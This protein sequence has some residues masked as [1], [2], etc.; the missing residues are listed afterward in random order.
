MSLLTTAK[1][2]K[3]LFEYIAPIQVSKTPA[4]GEASAPLPIH[5]VAIKATVSKNGV[6]YLPEEL[7]K[8]AET[9]KGKPII[10]DHEARMDNV[11][12]R[13][14]DSYYVPETQQV[15]FDGLVMDAKMQEMVLDGRAQEVSIGASVENLVEEEVNGETALTAY[16]MSGDELS[17]VVKPGVTGAGLS[18]SFENAMISICE[19]YQNSK[20]NQNKMT[21]NKQPIKEETQPPAPTAA[22][23]APASPDKLEEVFAMVKQMHELLMGAA[24]PAQPS[25]ESKKAPSLTETIKELQEKIAKLE[26]K[27][28]V[29][30][31]AAPK[32]KVATEAKP[33]NKLFEVKKT[34]SGA[35]EYAL[36]Y[37]SNR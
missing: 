24:Q 2:G 36:I 22:A 23:P 14:T 12:G 35:T 21:E 20:V 33:E 9:F 29:V 16:G 17:F 34:R 11:V 25:A 7:K 26:S 13:I 30:G 4:V 19:A 8:A 37:G 27:P 32:T 28:I 10:K 1:S 5:G 3:I 15:E 31:E 18:N 6:R